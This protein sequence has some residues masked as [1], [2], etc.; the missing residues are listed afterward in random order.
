[1]F[2]EFAVLVVI[3]GVEQNR[4]PGVEAKSFMQVS[5]SPCDRKLK[6][7]TNATFVEVGVITAV[8]TL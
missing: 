2:R 8:E 7:G 3:G 4:G 5:C 6:Q 1:M